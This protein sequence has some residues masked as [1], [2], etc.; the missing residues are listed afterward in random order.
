MGPGCNPERAQSRG[1]RCSANGGCSANVCDLAGSPGAASLRGA[2][3]HLSPCCRSLQRGGSHP[4]RR[5]E[6][7]VSGCQVRHG[8]SQKNHFQLLFLLVL[9]VQ[10]SFCSSLKVQLCL[11]LTSGRLEGK[12]EGPGLHNCPQFAFR[13]LAPALQWMKGHKGWCTLLPVRW[14]GASFL[15]SRLASSCTVSSF[16]GALPF[17]GP[18]WQGADTGCSPHG[19]CGQ[20]PPFLWADSPARCPML[21]RKRLE[22]PFGF[23]DQHVGQ[24][25]AVAT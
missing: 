22:I 17:L 8:N 6:A 16:S 9:V 24:S 15:I 19:G 13:C 1:C 23:K 3:T 14:L 5:E 10:E 20:A 25:W 4:L 7:A 21:A 12:T 11:R 2:R 18:L